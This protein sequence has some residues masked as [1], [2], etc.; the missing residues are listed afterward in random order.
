L[1]S[2]DL[3]AQDEIA[4]GR[5]LE[6]TGCVTNGKPC[7]CPWGH[8]IE[9]VSGFSMAAICYM[10]PGVNGCPSTP[11]VSNFVVAGTGFDYAAVA[12]S[13]NRSCGARAASCGGSPTAGS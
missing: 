13:G 2:A 10:D 7:S 12:E 5:R 9:M 11:V 8:H 1:V 4:F 3:V 6:A